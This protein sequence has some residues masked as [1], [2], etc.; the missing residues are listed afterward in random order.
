MDSI[1]A[2]KVLK[3]PVLSSGV[4]AKEWDGAVGSLDIRTRAELGRHYSL[5]VALAGVRAGH[6]ALCEHIALLGLEADLRG[7]R[8]RTLPAPVSL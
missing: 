3:L 6:N 2:S 1:Q 7:G 4:D 8:L 5:A